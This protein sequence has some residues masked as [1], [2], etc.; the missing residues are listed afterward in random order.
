[1]TE[2]FFSEL[3]R[4][5]AART[6]QGAHLPGVSRERRRRRRWLRRVAAGAVSVVVLAVSLVSEFPAAANGHVW[7]PAAPARSTAL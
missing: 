3:E 7:L 5:L 2:D 6:R 1:M 4:E